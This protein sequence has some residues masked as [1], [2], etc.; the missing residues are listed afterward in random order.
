M[1]IYIFDANEYTPFHEI[2]DLCV[3]LE[4]AQG[5]PEREQ[6]V[7]EAL[8]D[9]LYDLSARVKE[10]EA[11]GACSRRRLSSTSVRGETPVPWTAN[12]GGSAA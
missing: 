4:R 2:H 10:D 6:Q 3:R 12:A 9:A 5:D 1:P 8:R 11:R 7:G